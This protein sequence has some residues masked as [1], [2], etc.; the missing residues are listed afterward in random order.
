MGGTDY[1]GAEEEEIRENY[2]AICEELRG[3][4]DGLEKKLSSQDE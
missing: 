4:A 1:V 3:I 2:E